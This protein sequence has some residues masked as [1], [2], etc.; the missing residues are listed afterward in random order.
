MPLGTSPPPTTILVGSSWAAS[1]SPQ[2]SSDSQGSTSGRGAYG[3]L[4]GPGRLGACWRR[5]GGSRFRRVCCDWKV[6]APGRTSRLPGR[7]RQGNSL[8]VN[9]SA[10]SPEPTGGAVFTGVDLGIFNQLVITHGNDSA[11]TTDEIR[12]ATTWSAVTLPVPEPSTL[13]LVALGLIGCVARGWWQPR[14][15]APTS[16]RARGADSMRIAARQLFIFSS[17]AAGKVAHDP[18]AQLA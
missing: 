17:A 10:G 5:N 7:V 2:A 4:S 9:P 8:Y 3:S 11:W 12:V 16:G 6:R 13:A 15:S 14:Q 18:A 1:I